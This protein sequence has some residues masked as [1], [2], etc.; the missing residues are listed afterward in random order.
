MP[1]PRNHRAS[2]RGAALLLAVVAV[3]ILTVL[4][5]DLAYET[6]VRLRI[7]ANARDDLRAQALAQ[8]AV[9]MS[10]LVLA[11]QNQ[12]DQTISTIASA[13]ATAGGTGGTAPTAALP[14]PQLWSLVRVGAGLTQALFGDAGP[15]AKA[16]PPAEG[17]A[18]APTTV[19]YGDFEGGFEARIEDEGQKINA[20]L[21]SLGSGG[22]SAQVGVLLRMVC[23]T[24]WDPLFDRIDADGQRYSRTDLVNH[25]HDW[26]TPETTSSS[27]TASFPGGNCSFVL[28]AGNPFEKSFSDKNYAYDRGPDRYKSKNQRMDSLDEL[29]MVAGVTDAFMAAFGDQLTVYLPKDAAINVNVEGVEG[30]MRVAWAM[31]APTSYATLKDPAFPPRLHKALVVARMGGFFTMTP[32]QFAQILQDLKVT[33]SPQYLTQSASS[34]FTDRSVV[35]RVRAV[36]VAGDVTH[37]TEAVVSFAPNL[38][39]NASLPAG[40]AQLNLG[41]L[42]RW[43]EE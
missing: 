12:L 23:D 18:P 11:F 35:Y 43:R 8:S 38:A 21:D 36:G 10:R 33:V 25:L 16:A 41:Q 24:K 19:R 22:L 27:L 32:V 31:A 4:A 9:T 20:Q 37:E 13:Q 34:P 5:V 40:A 39:G 28:P 17:A 2:E 42:V 30:E 29:Y 3:A 14:R 15:E 6:Q 7:A 1:G 26:V